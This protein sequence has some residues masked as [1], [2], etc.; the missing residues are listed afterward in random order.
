MR[1]YKKLY[2]FSLLSSE[3]LDSFGKVF[4]VRE[5]VLDGGVRDEYFVVY[6]KKGGGNQEILYSPVEKI[7]RAAFTGAY[8]VHHLLEV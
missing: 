3:I 7:A 8:R 1:N 5:S 2:G 4:L 6:I